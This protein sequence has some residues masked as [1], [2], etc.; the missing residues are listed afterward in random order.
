MQDHDGVGKACEV[1][2]IWISSWCQNTH[3]G[4]ICGSANIRKSLEQ[5]NSIANMESNAL[6]RRGIMKGDV[7][8]DLGEIGDCALIET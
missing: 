6:G 8:A 2:P 3:P 5:L 7:A 4:E 1:D